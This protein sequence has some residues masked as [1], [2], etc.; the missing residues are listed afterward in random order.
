MSPADIKASVLGFTGKAAFAPN[1][2]IEVDGSSLTLEKLIA[3]GDGHPMFVSEDTVDRLM[4]SRAIVDRIVASNTPTY[5]VNTGFGLMSHTNVPVDQLKELQANLIR[6]HSSGVGESLSPRY[7][8]R[9][10]AL[11]INTLARGRSGVSLGTFSGMLK[12]FNA[13]LT[14]EV[15]CQGTVGASG[16]FPRP[17][18]RLSTQLA[19]QATWLHWRIWHLA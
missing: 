8:R 9:I 18:L 4:R 6:S 11:R 3:L 19:S 1:E 15:P 10:L 16:K 7:V 14:P 12:M 17:D 2:A 5:G 13:G